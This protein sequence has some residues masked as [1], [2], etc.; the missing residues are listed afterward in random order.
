LLNIP[1]LNKK[2][3]KMVAAVIM[4]TICI[5][6]AIPI[7]KLGE[8]SSFNSSI[9]Y[10]ILKGSKVIPNKQGNSKSFFFLPVGFMNSL[11]AEKKINTANK[12]QVPSHKWN[13]NP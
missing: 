7:M 2:Y 1:S 12:N 5:I 3:G 4:R 11:P 13:D 10:F 8:P 6:I 9:P